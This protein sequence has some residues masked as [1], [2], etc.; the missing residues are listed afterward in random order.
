[1]PQLEQGSVDLIFADPPYFLSN[2]GVT[3]QSGRMVSVNKGDWDASQGL[4]ADLEFTTAWLVECRRLL[5]PN[6]TIWIS[7]TMHNIHIIGFALQSLGYKILNEITWYKVNP[8]PN[9][10]CRYFTHATETIL[11]AK[12]TEKAKHKFN[13]ETMKEKNGGRQMQSLWSITPPKRWEKRYGKHPTQ[14]PEEL[15]ERIILAS[16]EPG[17]LVLDPFLGSATTGVMAVRLDRG[18]IGIEREEDYLKLA[19][20]RIKDEPSVP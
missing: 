10:S 16:S 6:G 9:L 12:K 4:G 5:K 17:D 1:M 14:K 3:C 7:G 2:N 18:F 11:W 20:Q 8:P 19:W 13:Y 15:L